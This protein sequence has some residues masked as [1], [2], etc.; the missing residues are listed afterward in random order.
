[1]AADEMRLIRQDRWDAALWG[2]VAT[3]SPDMDQTQLF[4]LFG[5]DDH[6]V[7]DEARDKLIKT[8]ELQRVAAWGEAV[9]VAK[10]SAFAEI[11]DTGIPHAF[12]LRNE[13]ASFKNCSM[14]IG[15]VGHGDQVSARTAQYIIEALSGDQCF[16]AI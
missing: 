6:W 8:R 14:L 10:R 5:T 2:S 3:S 7:S 16:A 12:P 1:M 11:D 4:F 15:C 13:F 9:A